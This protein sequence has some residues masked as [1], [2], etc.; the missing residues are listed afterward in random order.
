MSVTC[1]CMEESAKFTGRIWAYSIAEAA[2]RLPVL[3]G[4][5]GRMVAPHRADQP[6]RRA[7]LRGV[8]Q[9]CRGKELCERAADASTD[10]GR[11][12]KG[13]QRP[14]TPLPG[15]TGA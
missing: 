12:W 3:D 15:G 9:R 6:L 14:A 7:N 8:Q 11:P 2:A 5:T 4:R 1:G 10:P 13:P